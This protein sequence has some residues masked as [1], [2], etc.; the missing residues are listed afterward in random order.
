MNR[1]TSLVR[2][3]PLASGTDDTLAALFALRNDAAYRVARGGLDRVRSHPVIGNGRA[4][5]RRDEVYLADARPFRPSA[6]DSGTVFYAAQAALAGRPFVEDVIKGRSVDLPS[7]FWACLCC[8]VRFP[9]WPR[10]ISRG[11]SMQ[12]VAG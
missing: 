10:C 12:F 3:G 9:G 6:R 8:Y 7:H 4:V 11:H 5:Y 2:D 1:V